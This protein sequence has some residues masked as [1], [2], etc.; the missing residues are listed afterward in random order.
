MIRST[1]SR[2]PTPMAPATA[3]ER[4]D[5]RGFTLI[6]TLIAL[7]VLVAIAAI[8]VPPVLDWYED[9][10]FD[11]AGVIAVEH[12]RLSRAH[13]R[14][15]RRPVEVVYDT[16]RGVLAA[17]LLPLGDDD[18][19]DDTED[20]LAVAE[21]WAQAVL[22][23]G[24]TLSDTAPIDDDAI[25]PIAPAD[26]PGETIEPFT[27]VAFLPDGS[28][29]FSREAWLADDAGRNARLTVTRFTGVPSVER[30]P[31]S[32]EDDEPAGG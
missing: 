24:V 30:G 15:A 18:E 8:V 12:L 4:R 14:E 11:T 26:A 32:E 13:A 31:D 23:G 19:T 28:T 9:E 2:P 29:L 1:T 17:R 6:E 25:V 5:A 3:V 20:D 7:T 10:Q 27:I 16:E 22:P 21:P